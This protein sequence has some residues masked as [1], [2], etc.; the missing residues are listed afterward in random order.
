VTRG[1]T[2]MELVVLLAV[3]ALAAA[4]VAP[5]VSRR[6]D[7]VTARA[8]VAAVAAF[9][10]WAREQAVTRQQAA[11]VVLDRGGHALQLRRTGHEDG[12]PLASRLLPARWHVAPAGAR[13]VFLP[14][15][16]SSGAR[17]VLEAPG[18]R[19]YVVTVDALTGR[20]TTRR[21]DS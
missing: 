15:G 7:D 21:G 5:A 3:L 9:L 6:V 10:R 16:M 17:F 13:V 2:L 8:E 18:S 12:P 11:E 1:Y 20:V 4:V 19:V 14:H